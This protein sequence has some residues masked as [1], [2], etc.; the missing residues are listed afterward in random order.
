MF[1]IHITWGHVIFA[2]ICVALYDVLWDFPI[3]DDWST[4]WFQR[5]NLPYRIIGFGVAI[6]LTVLAQTEPMLA[7]W[8]LA[9]LGFVFGGVFWL[10]YN[11]VDSNEK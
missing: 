2:L 10:Q 3:P 7:A 1:S 6:V 8:L 4:R 5:K 11:A 9:G